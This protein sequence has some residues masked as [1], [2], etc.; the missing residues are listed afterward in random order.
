MLEQPDVTFDL[1]RLNLSQLVGYP[2]SVFSEQ[3]AGKELTTRI[4]SVQQNQVLI[5]AGAHQGMIDSLV[6]NQLLTVRLSYKGQPIAIQA[7]LRKS[8]GGRTYLVLE[9]RVSPVARRQF[10]RMLLV[11]E[12]KLATLPLLSLAPRKLSSLRWVQTESVD[13][14]SGGVRVSVPSSLQRDCTVLITIALQRPQLDSFPK[15][16]LAQVRHSFSNDNRLFQS[17]MQ[18]FTSDQITRQFPPDRLADLPESIAR[19][20]PEDR[21]QFNEVITTLMHTS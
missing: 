10:T 18:F 2:I 17:G 9:E 21:R 6:G 15:F 4:L 14:S 20:R 7:T 1:A 13:F 5:D 8:N 19:Y 12:V 16:L 11:Q 3:F